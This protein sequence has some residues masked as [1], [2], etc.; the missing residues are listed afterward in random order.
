MPL[1]S[2]D[3]GA[4]YQVLQIRLYNIKLYYIRL[5]AI[6]GRAI[7]GCTISGRAIFAVKSSPHVNASADSITYLH[8]LQITT[9]YNKDE[10]LLN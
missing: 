6:L 9:Y 4:Q 8:G 1:A 2:N 3:N 10:Y 5:S 7:S